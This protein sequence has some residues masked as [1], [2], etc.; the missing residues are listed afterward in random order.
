MEKIRYAVI[1]T[2]NR[3]RQLIK[4]ALQSGQVEIAA[5]ADSHPQSLRLGAEMAGGAKTF[6]DYRQMLEWGKFD[7]V[8]IAA[9]N[10]LHEQML[11]DALRCDVHILCEKPL[12]NSLAAIDRMLEKLRGFRKVFQIGM[13][14]RHHPMYRQLKE[15]V[16]SGQIGPVRMMWCKEFRVPFRDGVDNWRRSRERTGGS[17]L[18]K[19]CHHFD[20]FNW[21][22]D[23]RPVKVSAFGGNRG[24]DD[25]MADHAWVNV[26]YENRIRASLGLALFLPHSRLELGLVG[27]DGTA[28]CTSPDEKL[29][30]RSR[31][32]DRRYD[33]GHLD[34]SPFDHGGELEQHL[35]FVERI[36]T[37]RPSE[38]TLESIRDAHL[39]CVAAE[40]SMRTG[41][42]VDLSKGVFAE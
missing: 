2:G 22:A 21:I 7:A 9:P 30:I 31:K 41:E 16:R 36:R 5:I 20:L 13:E 28:V 42:T 17:L 26:E 8:V 10:D 40:K 25:G 12:G 38:V 39:I 6:S 18:E 35:A 15:A 29:T 33:Y 11:E 4:A 27:D 1:G 14:L 19:N 32:G 24:A 37:G 23:S 3:G 34:D